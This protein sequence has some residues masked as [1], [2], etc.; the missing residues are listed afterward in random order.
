MTGHPEHCKLIQ[1]NY[2]QLSPW[3]SI[4]L[5]RLPKHQKSPKNAFFRA[6]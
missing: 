6:S 4:L 3:L 1:D 5:R 2:S